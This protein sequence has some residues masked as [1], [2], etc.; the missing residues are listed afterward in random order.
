MFILLYLWWTVECD[1]GIMM[2]EKALKLVIGAHPVNF[3][4]RKKI[5]HCNCFTR[6]IHVHSKVFYGFHL[7]I[8]VCVAESFPLVQCFLYICQI[9][10]FLAQVLLAWLHCRL[11]AGCPGCSCSYAVTS[12]PWW[13]FVFN[14]VIGTVTFLYYL[15][16]FHACGMVRNSLCRSTV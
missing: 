10:M 13:T 5:S 1:C 12:L 9:A 7:V 3:Y 4:D 14:R 6:S 2:S 16:S 15:D 8:I 11:L